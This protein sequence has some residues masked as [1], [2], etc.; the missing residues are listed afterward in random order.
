M[1]SPPQIIVML[2]SLI[3]S[4]PSE[5]GQVEPDSILEPSTCSFE[6]SWYLAPSEQK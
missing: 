1:H 6:L 5:K 4:I 3:F 2:F